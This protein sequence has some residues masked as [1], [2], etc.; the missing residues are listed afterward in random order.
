MAPDTSF[1]S[2]S[3]G[4]GR[5]QGRPDPP[6]ADLD[7]RRSAAHTC[8]V[9]RDDSLLCWGDNARGQLGDGT[10]AGRASPEPVTKPGG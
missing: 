8:A 6:L 5:S 3:A 7:G 1:R 10:T 2:V 9:G 4:G